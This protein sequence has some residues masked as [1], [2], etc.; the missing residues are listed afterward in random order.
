MAYD[1]KYDKL[2][3]A[4]ESG[5]QSEAISFF[6]RRVFDVNESIRYLFED[7]K[8]FVVT[9]LYWSVRHNCPKLCR[10]LLRNGA[11]PYGTVVYEYYPLHE[12]CNRGYDLVVQEFVSARGVEM[13][14]VNS[15]ADT[16]LH[17]ACM[18]GHIQC[19]HILLG[20][21]SDCSLRNKLGHTPL[22]SAVYHDRTDLVELFRAHNKGTY[23][24]AHTQYITTFLCFIL[25]NSIAQVR[26]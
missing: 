15:D 2:L 7:G 21:G 16:P 4:I 18:R 12:A 17:V 24:Y 25:D 8:R 6:E 19:V 3:R 1:L 9:P 10:Y 13:D 14:K 22:Q 20:A 11:R 5:R 26:L 23:T